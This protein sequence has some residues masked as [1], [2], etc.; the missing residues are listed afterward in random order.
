MTWANM[1]R[2]PNNGQIDTN[3]TSN[4]N[5]RGNGDFDVE[6][7]IA[8]LNILNKDKL[9]ANNLGLAK[10]Q[11]WVSNIFDVFEDEI[12]GLVLAH[13]DLLRLFII[14]MFQPLLRKNIL[15]RLS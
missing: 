15:L 13:N 2:L 11:R 12:Q 5:F 9:N 6:Q 7:K 3:S 4:E 10:A 8:I 14:L 1:A